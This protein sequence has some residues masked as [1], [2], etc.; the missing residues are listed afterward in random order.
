MNKLF[1]DTELAVLLSVIAST[2]Q[3]DEGVQI[4]LQDLTGKST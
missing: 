1:D 3:S 2:Y 4:S